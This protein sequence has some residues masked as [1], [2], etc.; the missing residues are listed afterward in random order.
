MPCAQ[1]D[2]KQC[3]VASP[4][5]FA[6]NGWQAMR[7][8]DSVRWVDPCKGA[9]SGVPMAVQRVCPTCNSMSEVMPDILL[10]KII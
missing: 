5:V 1:L 9:K 3:G 4:D 8:G 10:I 2:A 7:L 6:I